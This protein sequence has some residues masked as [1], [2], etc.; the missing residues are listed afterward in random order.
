MEEI[1]FDSIARSVESAAGCI[2]SDLKITVFT[3]FLK[4]IK[5]SILNHEGVRDFTCAAVFVATAYQAA[6]EDEKKK[7]SI[8]I[9]EEILVVPQ[10]VKVL[11]L[12]WGRGQLFPI[13]HCPSAPGPHQ[14]K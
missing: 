6:I 2:N 13:I 4:L 9:E 5:H 3:R 1:L 7:L 14:S 8:H 10:L 11:N 12:F